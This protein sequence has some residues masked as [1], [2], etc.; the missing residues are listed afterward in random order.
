V[1]VVYIEINTEIC[2]SREA[3]IK[4]YYLV[5]DTSKIKGWQMMIIIIIKYPK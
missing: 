2:H 5:M 3:F 1:V 4:K